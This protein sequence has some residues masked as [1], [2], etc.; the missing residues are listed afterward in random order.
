MN[1]KKKAMSEGKT[2]PLW[3][4]LVFD[5]FK[6]A[7]GGRVR[8]IIS[9]GAP[10]S[11]QCCEFLAVCFGTPV[12]QGYGLTE[13]CGGSIIREEDSIDLQA[14][15]CG[16]PFPCCE[17]KLVDVPEMNYTHNDQPSPRGEIWLRGHSIASGYYKNPQKT[18]EEWTQ[19]GWF[20]TG[21]IGLLQKDL[22]LSIIDRKKN[23][24]KP[25]HGEYIAPEKLEAVFK[26]S[27]FID[28]IMI[29]AS[30]AHNDL[31]AFVAPN[32]KALQEF[33]SKKGLHD[34]EWPELCNHK[35]AETAVL[36]SLGSIWKNE[37]LKSMERISAVK[38]FPEEW[39][40]ENGWLTAAMKL[41]RN[42]I[43]KLHAP[44]LEHIYS[45]LEST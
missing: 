17:A 20:K 15:S 41:R 30:S 26:N 23:L 9:G 34:I 14:K 28:N 12:C 8:I 38:L 3:N 39:T 22:T 19:D 13:T 11:P 45:K 36:E 5:K 43:H 27:P 7:L 37:K 1:P 2:T 29:Y 24:V 40:T 31:V 32:K 18:A 35:A 4:K 16:T 33:A 42:E 44:T 10:L 25:P 21:D 6:T